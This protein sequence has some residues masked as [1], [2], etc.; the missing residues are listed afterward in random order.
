MTIS[1]MDTRVPQ[2]N[3]Y[4]AYGVPDEIAACV[5]AMLAERNDCPETVVDVIDG[6]ILRILDPWIRGEG[7]IDD[8]GSIT[9]ID[10][11]FDVRVQK[12]P[13][14]LNLR[15]GITYRL[16]HNTR[17]PNST[18]SVLI[19]TAEAICRSII[20]CG[21][22]VRIPVPNGRH[23]E[24]VLKQGDAI[25]PMLQFNVQPKNDNY[26]LSVAN[27]SQALTAYERPELYRR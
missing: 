25:K 8:L 22:E 5:D 17:H 15:P 14:V 26:W 6:A 11:G 16:V 4:P 9:P 21:Y 27:L 7:I 10:T 2:P 12:M 23:I 20:Q 3:D 13:V 18:G 24:V 1:I 19:G